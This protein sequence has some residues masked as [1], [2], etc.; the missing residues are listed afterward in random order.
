MGA[1]ILWLK[2]TNAPLGAQGKGR[3]VGEEEEEEEGPGSPPPLPKGGTCSVLMCE[4]VQA[5][6]I[7][8]ICVNARVGLPENASTGD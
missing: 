2:E 4:F 5:V 7:M 8:C 1:P 3:Q 6:Y